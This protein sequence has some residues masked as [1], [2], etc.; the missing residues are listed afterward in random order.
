MT[1]HSLVY[2]NVYININTFNCQLFSEIY[3]AELIIFVPFYINYFLFDVSQLPAHCCGVGQK[4]DGGRA[5][6]DV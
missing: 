1:C 3:C 4:A 5:S 2:S 6:G